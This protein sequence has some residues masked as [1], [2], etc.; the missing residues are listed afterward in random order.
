[1]C[2]CLPLHF[3]RNLLTNDLPPLYIFI[4]ILNS[5]RRFNRRPERRETRSTSAEATVP[6]SDRFLEAAES[7]PAKLGAGCSAGSDAAAETF[8]FQEGL[9]FQDGQLSLPPSFDFVFFLECLT[10]LLMHDHFQIVLKAV[11]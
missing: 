11:S 8:K 6:T 2:I 1:M 7:A 9:S 4:I 5:N 3:V 10:G